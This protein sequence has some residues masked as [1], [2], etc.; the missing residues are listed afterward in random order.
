MEGADKKKSKI[1]KWAKRFLIVLGI[2]FAIFIST[3][4]QPAVFLPH[5]KI[6]IS[7]PFAPEYDAD[8]HLIPMGEIEEW[9]NASTGSPDG[10][11]GIDFQ[12]NRE[13]EIRSVGDG[14]ITRVYLNHEGEYIVEQ[15]LGLYYRTMYQELNRLAPGIDTSS[16][17]KKGE[18]IGYTSYHR[19]EFGDGPPDPSDPSMQLHWDFASSSMLVGRLCPLGYFDAESRKRIEKIWERVKSKGNYKKEFPDICNGAFKNKEK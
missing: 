5:D 17:V 14:G 16:E 9:H 4:I 13:V 1:W 8:V 3:I 15:S 18:L 7:L 10:H 19:T 12:W 11:P 6:E 2:L